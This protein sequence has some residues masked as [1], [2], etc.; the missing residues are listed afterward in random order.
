MVVTQTL[1]MSMLLACL[2]G[3]GRLSGDSEHIALYAGGISFFRMVRP[4]AWMGIVISIF[5][6]LWSEAVMPPALL[7]SQ[8]ADLEAPTPDERATSVDIALSAA[9][10][11]AQIRRDLGAR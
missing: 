4:V 10:Q 2:L 9:E 3:F 11:V 5:T 6:F 7:D 1:P 8:L